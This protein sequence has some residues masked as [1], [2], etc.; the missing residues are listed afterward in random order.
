MDLFSPELRRDPYPAYAAARARTPVLH[1]PDARLW[2]VLG[3]DAVKRVLSDHAVFRSDVAPARGMAFEWL[4]FMDPPRHTRLRALI[5]RAFTSRTVAALAPAITRLA[6]ERIAATLDHGVIDVVSELATPVPMMVIAELIGLP[7]SDWPVLARWSEAIV[8]LGNTIVGG[9]A[10]RA[11][12]VFAAANAE[13]AVYFAAAIADRRVAP[14]DDLLTRLVTAEVDGELL[15]E[16]ELIRFCQLLL[17]AGT[18]TTTNLIDNALVCFAT[19][20]D[21]LARVRAEPALLA[22]AIEE[23]LRFRTP[24]Q[25]MFRATAEPV[26]LDGTVV[27]AGAFVVAMIGAANRDPRRFVAPDTFDVGRT[28]NPH[29]AFGH[30]IHFCVGAPLARL[31]AAIVLGELLR[32]WARFEL[33]DPAW[34]PRAAFHVHGPSAL[35]IRFTPA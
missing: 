22:P 19:Y 21:Q 12:A 29:V 15:A 20:P 24:V 11:G 35:P 10:A 16:P 9:D 1:L 5:S 4:L 33:V 7:P 8:Q 27:P 28:P 6:V 26:E 25:A 23:V 14:R 17:A 32:R 3:H 13:M 30:G 31:E 18:E 2:A 34:P